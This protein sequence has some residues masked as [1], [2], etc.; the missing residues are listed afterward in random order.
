MKTSTRLPLWLPLLAVACLSA[1][2]IAAQTCGTTTANACPIRS[3]QAVTMAFDPSP[4]TGVQ[5]YRLYVDNTRVGPDIPATGASV[6]LPGQPAGA[7]AVQLTAFNQFGE[8]P[9]SAALNL[10]AG[11]PPGPPSGLRV[12]AIQSVEFRHTPEG[13][14]T[15]LV[16]YQPQPPLP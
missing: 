3:G 1:S 15:F 7:H 5:G 10:L 12:P 2:P 16:K 14:T 13:E 4:A 11:D 9:R 8:G 6:S